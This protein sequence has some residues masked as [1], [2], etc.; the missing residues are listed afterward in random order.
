M[1]KFRFLF[2][3]WKF[4]QKSAIAHV[5]NIKI[6]CQKIKIFCCVSN[7]LTRLPTSGVFPLAGFVFYIGASGISGEPNSQPQ[8]RQMQPSSQGIM[9]SELQSG[10]LIMLLSI[11]NCSCC[12]GTSA[13]HFRRWVCLEVFSCDFCSGGTLS[14][15]EQFFSSS[16]LLPTMRN[17]KNLLEVSI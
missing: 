2:S 13:L 12:S 1:L 17:R 3:C 9:S 10:H 6:N 8:S 14:V 7:R 4:S 16:E 15:T 5:Q 11:G